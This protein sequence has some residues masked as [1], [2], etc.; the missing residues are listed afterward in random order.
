MFAIE[1]AFHETLCQAVVEGEEVRLARTLER[2]TRKQVKGSYDKSR[3]PINN[4]HLTI[5]P[6]NARKVSTKIKNFAE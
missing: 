3:M 5:W 1:I 6:L 4:S 2:S